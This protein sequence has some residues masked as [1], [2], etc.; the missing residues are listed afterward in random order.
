MLKC[1]CIKSES[2]TLPTSLA[3]HHSDSVSTDTKRLNVKNESAW[4]P[5]KCVLINSTRRAQIS[6]TLRVNTPRHL[7]LS[8][9]RAQTQHIHPEALSKVRPISTEAFQNLPNQLVSCLLD[10][11]AGKFTPY[12]F[13]HRRDVPF[14]EASPRAP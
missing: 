9:S 13:E 3:E 7:K 10:R 11:S 6:L 5:L 1:G 8:K 2:T 12:W 14:S 4:V